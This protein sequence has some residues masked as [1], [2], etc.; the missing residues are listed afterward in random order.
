MIEAGR[1]VGKLY[2]AYRPLQARDRLASFRDRREADERGVMGKFDPNKVP[3]GY[4]VDTDMFGDP[5]LRRKYTPLERLF[6]IVSRLGACRG[7]RD[8]EEVMLFVA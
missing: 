4:E 8:D 3:E 2:N 7:L 6:R 5:F 1:V